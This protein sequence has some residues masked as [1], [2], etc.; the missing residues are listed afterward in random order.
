[1]E[2]G[3]AE[4]LD[5]MIQSTTFALECQIPEGKTQGS[6]GHSI[7]HGAWSDVLARVSSQKYLLNK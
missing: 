5:P 4:V 3:N 7:I 1:M 6:L 2:T